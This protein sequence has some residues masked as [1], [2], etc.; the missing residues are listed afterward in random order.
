M[1]VSMSL[2]WHPQ[3]CSLDCSSE[4]GVTYGQIQKN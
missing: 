4:T 2:P 1:D 3:D